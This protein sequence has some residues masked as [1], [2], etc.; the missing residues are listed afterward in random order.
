MGDGGSPI[1]AAASAAAAGPCPS[2]ARVVDSPILFMV[3]FHKAFRKELDSLH[4]LVSSSSSATGA[5]PERETL[6]ELRK[7]YRFLQSVYKYHNAAEDE[8]T[9]TLNSAFIYSFLHLMSKFWVAWRLM[10]NGVFTEWVG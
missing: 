10:G 5:M 3:C 8:V 2:A 6:I 9:S 7:R 4:V 1:Q